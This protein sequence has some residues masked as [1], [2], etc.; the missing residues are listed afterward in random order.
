M[1]YLLWI[2][3]YPPCFGWQPVIGPGLK[4]FKQIYNRG[5]VLLPNRETGAVGSIRRP[6]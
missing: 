1:V 4:S 6:L 5:C 3:K 2:E